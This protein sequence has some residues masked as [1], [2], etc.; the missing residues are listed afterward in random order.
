[1]FQ[2]RCSD[3]GKGHAVSG[4]DRMQCAIRVDLPAAAPDDN[5]PAEETG[6]A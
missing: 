2:I 4:P 1:M 3:G 5:L 6:L